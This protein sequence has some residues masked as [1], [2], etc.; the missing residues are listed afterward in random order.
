MAIGFG[1]LCAANI[2]PRARRRR[3]ETPDRR[4]G[5]ACQLDAFL[6]AVEEGKPIL[7]VPD[8]AVCQLR[9]IDRCDE[10]AGL[11]IRGLDLS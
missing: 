6:D 1:A 11:P 7:T 10:A 5:Y 2:T 9:I 8:D 3:I 4:P